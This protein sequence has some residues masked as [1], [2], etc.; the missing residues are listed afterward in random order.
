MIND[1]NINQRVNCAVYHTR[2]IS[3]SRENLLTCD[4][5]I[6]TSQT[7]GLFTLKNKSCRFD[8][9]LLLPVFW[10]RLYFTL[11]Q[12]NVFFVIDNHNKTD[13]LN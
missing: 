5:L 6:D 1:V 3:V 8:P 9:L 10:M 2:I 11:S 4:S 7:F 12:V 13:P